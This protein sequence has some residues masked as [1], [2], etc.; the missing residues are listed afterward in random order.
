MSRRRYRAKGFGRLSAWTIAIVHPANW[1][2]GSS[3]IILIAG[4]EKSCLVPALLFESPY[5]SQQ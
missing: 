4:A 3:R 5:A 2:P 1:R